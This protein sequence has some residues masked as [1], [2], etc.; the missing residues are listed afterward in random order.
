MSDLKQTELLTADGVEELLVADDRA[1]IDVYVPEWKKTIRLRQMTAAEIFIIS[2][3][4]KKD[5]MFVAVAMC[6]VDG[7]GN[8]LFKDPN[9]LRGKSANAMSLLQNEVMKLNGLSINAAAIA[10]NG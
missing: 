10:K 9:R 5:A 4:D 8:L 6:A 2:E 7:N 1:T 3:T